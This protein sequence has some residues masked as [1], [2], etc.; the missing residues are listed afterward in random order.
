MDAIALVQRFGKPDIFLTITCNPSWPEIA[1]KL[2]STD[3]VQNR[4]DLVSRVFRAKIEELKND[5]IKRHIFGKIAAFMYTIEFQKRGLPHAHFL[6]I[7]NE[8]YKLLTPE[9]YDRFVCAEIPDENIYPYLYSLVTQHMMHGPCGNLNPTNSCMKKKGC[10]KNKYPKEFA[11]QTTKG[12]NSYPIYRRRNTGK[13]VKIRGHFLDN[14]WVVPYNPYL[15]CK[16]NCHI[17]VE[18]C[19]D[20]KVVKY[21]Y[22]YICKGHDKIAFHIQTNDVNV[23]IDEIKEYQSARWVSPPEAAWRIFAFP[24]SEMNPTVYHL[25]LHLDGQQLVSFKSTDNISNIANNPIIRKTML[26]EFFLM[27]KSNKEA[28]DLNLLYREFPEHFVWS[29]TDK[30][31]TRRKRGHVIGRVVTCHPTEGERYYLR[32][33]LMNVRGPK[34][35]EDLRSVNGVQYNSFRE[36]AEKRE[37]LLCDNNLVECMSEAASYQMPSSLRQLFAM[38]L[39]YC[40]PTNP[41]ELWERFESP[42]S[43]DFSKSSNINV[44]EIRYKVLNY[45]NDILHSMGRDI[46]EFEL[47]SEY[48]KPSSIARE[49]KEVHYERNIIVSEEDLLLKDKLNSEQIKAYNIIL[50]RVL[51]NKFGAF[52]IDGPGGTGKSFLYRALLAT[53]R[54]R[55]LIA[56]ATASSGVAAS[57]LPGGRTAHSRFKIPIDVDENFTCNISKQSSLASLIRDARLIVWDEISMAKKKMVEAFDLLLRDLMERNTLFG[58]K[59]VVFS[60]DFRQTLPVVRSGKK[61]DF[62]R[63]CLLCSEIWNELE[64]LQLSKNMRATKDPDFCE[65]LMRIGSGKEKTNDRGKIEIPHSLIIPFTSEKESLDLLFKNTYPDLYKCCTKTSFVTSRAILTTKNDFVDDIN[66]MLI[67]RFSNIEKV[68]IAIDETID[69][70]DQSEYEDFLHTLNP[71]GLP[72]YKLT[73]KK[74][75]P[76][77]LLRNLNP[78]EGLC[79]GTRLICNDFKPHVISA[80]ISTGDFKNTHVFIPRIPL[81]TSEDEKLPLPFKRTQFPVRLCFA[82]TINKAQGQTL[83]FVGIYLREPVF[84]HGQLYVALSRATSSNNVKVL[85]RPPI[86]DENDDHSTY[87]VVYNEVIEKAFSSSLCYNLQW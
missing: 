65:F 24:I 14:L 42:M 18:I 74:N 5:I 25:Q 84:S 33:L 82:M 77:M 72:P 19:S 51:S 44:R 48:I 68:Y 4:P 37:L 2:I 39:I 16:F 57:L 60:G 71:T 12:K 1:E 11:E 35:Y 75:C 53:V 13:V 8:N 58:G 67:S 81:M 49:A 59:I 9:A 6:I 43:D 69:P 40:N 63:E 22:K 3:E 47:I 62:I 78:C 64:K 86:I 61:E 38:L 76:I 73:L 31:W 27:N 56:L 87:N 55:G 34:S 41:R 15:L 17:N 79:N 54:H 10:C 21:I 52:F 45:I 32:L 28:T 20:I 66:D 26:T 46:N 50:D 85:I 30:I 36:A 23:E 83:D 70:K 7:L 29:T 80:I